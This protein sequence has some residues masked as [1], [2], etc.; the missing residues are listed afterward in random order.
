MNN[1]AQLKLHLN[2][3]S[4]H[5]L[6]STEFPHSMKNLDYYSPSPNQR[7]SMISMEITEIYRISMKNY[8]DSMETN[9][10]SMGANG[11]QWK[12]MKF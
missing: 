4:R 9:G 12:S 10:I 1:L 6:N 5:K 11:N 2:G 7:K 3:I 8:G